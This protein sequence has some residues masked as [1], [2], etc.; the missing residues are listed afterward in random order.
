MVGHAFWSQNA[1]ATYQRAMN[2]FFQDMLG[3]HMQVYTDDIMVKFKRASEHVNHLK[4][5][6][7]RMRHHQLKLNPLKYAFGVHARNFLIFLVH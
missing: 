4:K 3:H 6:F 1:G 5:S 7:E 2:A